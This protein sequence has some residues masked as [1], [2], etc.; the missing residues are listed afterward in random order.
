MSRIA[1]IGSGASAVAAIEGALSSDSDIEI[2]V[3]DP[4]NEL[5]QT[6]ENWDQNTPTQIAK[7]SRYGSLAMYEYPSNVIDFDAGMHIPLSGTVGGLTTV[8]GANSTIPE[9]DTLV[10]YTKRHTTEAIKW[11][12]EYAHITNLSKVSDQENFFVSSRFRNLIRK[13]KVINEICINPAT[14]SIIEQKC[15]KFGGCLTGCKEH[16]IFSAEQAI[17]GLV[18]RGSINLIKSFVLKI[19][20]K[21]FSKF[22]LSVEGDLGGKSLDYE[23]DKIIITCGA[24]ASC[25][26]LQ[27]SDLVSK[28]ITLKDTQVFYSA[29]YMLENKS[30][31]T[32]T[33]ELAQVFIRKSK[34]LHISMY[35]FSN[36]FIHRA[37]LV[38]G[39]LV[40]IIPK[41]F[42]RHIVA[43]IG[44]IGPEQ[45]GSLNLE[46]KNNHTYVTQNP[47][48]ITK[49]TIAKN[50]S[51]VRNSLKGLGL[52][53]IPFLTQIPNVGASYHVG[54]ANVN[55]N[56]TFTPVGKIAGRDDLEIYVLDSAALYDLPVG[57]VTTTVMAA[58]YGRAKLALEND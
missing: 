53:Q 11:V 22:S 14:L 13:Y 19:I 1:V 42:W 40:G 34:Q 4:W 10:N 5:P 37:K 52:F 25:A 51:L 15:T 21:D 7:K 30:E 33:L 18:N 50:M 24:I 17:Y 29:F 32:K 44:F 6:I 57:P 58:A 56:P 45:S 47:N 31:S 8:W 35:E 2:D 38:I 41:R 26:L 3:Y 46:Y 27:R 48:S 16:A 28:V 12:I 39:P 55:G 23:Y 20:P 9:S 54:G 36:Q 43:G 49:D